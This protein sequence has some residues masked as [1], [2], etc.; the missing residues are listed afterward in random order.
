MKLEGNDPAD[1]L[2]QEVSDFARGRSVIIK[3]SKI[4]PA[5]IELSDIESRPRGRG[6]GTAVM[7]TLIAAANKYN[8]RIELEALWQGPEGP[9][10]PGYE[11][12]TK[13]Q[14]RLEQWYAGFG[15]YDV[16]DRMEPHGLHMRYEP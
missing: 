8:V 14:L 11:A 9:Y 12:P 6:N 15:F 1:R 4:G 2:I 16:H 3:L 7:R 13:Q 5:K 10:E